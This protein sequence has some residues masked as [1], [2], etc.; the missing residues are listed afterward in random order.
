MNY[1]KYFF[2]FIVSIM[3]FSCDEILNENKQ[4]NNGECDFSVWIKNI[5]CIT[6]SNNTFRIKIGWVTNKKDYTTKHITIC[7]YGDNGGYETV[8]PDKQC[9]KPNERSKFSTGWIK[10]N[11][12]SRYEFE[13]D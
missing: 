13:C 10:G 12:P 6:G 3:I 1:H 8:N 5:E 7:V 4:T 11:S 9:L 2:I